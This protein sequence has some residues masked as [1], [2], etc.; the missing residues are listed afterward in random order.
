MGLR[1]RGATRFATVTEE[2]HRLYA[3]STGLAPTAVAP[4]VRCGWSGPESGAIS[5]NAWR[6]T[7]G[8][9]RLPPPGSGP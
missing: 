1:T 9:E 4:A 3:T 2:T 7:W 6:L 8:N 5:P